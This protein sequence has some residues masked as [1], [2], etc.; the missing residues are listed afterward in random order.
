MLKTFALKVVIL[1][2]KVV[3]HVAVVVIAIVLMLAALVISEL[4]GRR[5]LHID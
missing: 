2:A 3:R 5:I 1:L 4:I